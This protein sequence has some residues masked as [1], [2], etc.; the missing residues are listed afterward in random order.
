MA[1]VISGPTARFAPRIRL[2]LCGGAGR[3]FNDQMMASG[4]GQLT[5]DYGLGQQLAGLRQRRRL[6]ILVT[7]GDA[8]RLLGWESRCSRMT[9]RASS[10]TRRKGG[11]FFGD[12]RGRGSATIDFNNDGAMDLVLTAWPTAP[13]CSRN[14]IGAAPGS[15]SSSKAVRRIPRAGAH[16]RHGGPAHQFAEARCRRV[17]GPVRP[18]PALRPGA[19]LRSNASKS[20]PS[21]RTQEVRIHR[22]TRSCGCGSRTLNGV[23]GGPG[24]MG[25]VS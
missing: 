21:G 4:L 10:P 20:L 16:V 15:A 8:H 19:R 25:R 6:D 11:R 3:T 18:S 5:A 7:N 2:V 14:V 12:I 24:R 1:P 17:P 23:P 13:S 9:A 22:S